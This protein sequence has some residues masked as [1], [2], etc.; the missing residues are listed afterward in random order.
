M[1]KFRFT[2]EIVGF[3][4]TE[5]EAWL[6]AV[7]QFFLEPGIMPTPSICTDYINKEKKEGVID[8]HRD[9]TTDI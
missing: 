7:E 3:G 4:N 1:M 5:K 8:G 2:V 6:D 9:D